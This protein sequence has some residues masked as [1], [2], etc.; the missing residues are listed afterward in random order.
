MEEKQNKKYLEN[1]LP[2]TLFIPYFAVQIENYSL[3]YHVSI[4]RLNFYEFICEKKRES[5]QKSNYYFYLK[6]YVLHIV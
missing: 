5:K 2:L 1:K 4:F 6:R 3:N